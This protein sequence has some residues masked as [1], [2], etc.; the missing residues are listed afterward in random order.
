MTYHTLS[1]ILLASLFTL[2][3]PSCTSTA[4][5]GSS[6]AF[7]QALTEAA[8]V[9]VIEKSKDPQAMAAKVLALAGT[10]ASTDS[11]PIVD[12]IHSSLGYDTLPVSEQILVDAAV[13][14]FTADLAAAADSQASKLAVLERWR[15]VATSAARRYLAV[16]P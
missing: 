14:A 11:T 7:Q 3:L 10:P 13:D 4:T 9:R 15:T 16:H 2:T 1:A 12:L 6:P 5:L 8:I